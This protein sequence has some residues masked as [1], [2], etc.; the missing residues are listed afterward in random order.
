MEAVEAEVVV[1]EAVEVEAV[2]EDLPHHN[3]RNSHNNNRMWRQQRMSKQWE[4][5]QI[6]LM[7]TEPKPKTLSRR[8]RDI[9]V[10]TK[11]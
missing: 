5:S 11:M 8:S 9:S 6:H 10:L 2:E 3:H 4:S 1:E 7:V